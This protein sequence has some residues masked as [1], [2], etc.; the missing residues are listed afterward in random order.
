MI[1]VT[2]PAAAQILQ[3][4]GMKVRRDEGGALPS[5]ASLFE[6]VADFERR[7]IT[8]RLTRAQATHFS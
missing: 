2:P 3:S 1:T 4:A 6:I 8:E 5:D 7:V